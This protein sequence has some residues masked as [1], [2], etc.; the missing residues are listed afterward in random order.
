[1][2]VETVEDLCEQLADWL[3]IYG[4][5]KAAEDNQDCHTVDP[6]CCRTGFMIVMQE[7]INEAVKNDRMMNSNDKRGSY[8]ATK[9][10]DHFDRFMDDVEPMLQK[11]GAITTGDVWSKLSRSEHSYSYISSQF[12]RVM[13]L[14][15]QQGKARKER[16]GHWTILIPNKKH[17]NKEM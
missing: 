15:C 12:K 11:V 1:M 14:M 6:R 10:A 8:M 4:C 13:E 9:A 5:C 2:V 17:G 7:R 3:G 16:N